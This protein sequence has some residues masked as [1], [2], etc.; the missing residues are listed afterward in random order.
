MPKYTFECSG[1]NVLF[2]RKLKMG[3]HPEHPCPS[4]GEMA[5]RQWEGESFGFDFQEGANPGNS[6]V[7]KLDN[8]TADQAVGRDAE[9]RWGELH[10]RDKVKQTVR[11]KGGHRA[12]IRTHGVE[13]GK[14]YVEYEGGTD[15]LL[16]A[17][18]K[19]VKGAEKAY[20]SSS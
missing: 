12:L 9:K 20:E 14:P 1:C 6:G 3:E 16:E 5:P 19:L 15:S 11:E 8:P 13:N 7:S 18:K 4:C 17:R 2:T 10:A